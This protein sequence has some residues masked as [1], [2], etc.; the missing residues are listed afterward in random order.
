MQGFEEASVPLRNEANEVVK[1]VFN[2]LTGEPKPS[3]LGH[4]RDF[5]DLFR[6]SF[7]IGFR[8]A[9]ATSLFRLLSVMW[10]WTW[11]L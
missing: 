4:V 7:Q 3:M 5:F 2:V 8:F 11:P 10:P 1:N 6:I 9:G